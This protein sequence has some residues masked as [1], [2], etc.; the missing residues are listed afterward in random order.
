MNYVEEEGLGEDIA[1]RDNLTNHANN[2]VSKKK[3]INIQ[4]S[5]NFVNFKSLQIFN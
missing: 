3:K 2:F 1:Q 5:Q 4:N